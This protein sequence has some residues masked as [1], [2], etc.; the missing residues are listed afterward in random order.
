[1]HRNQCQTKVTCTVHNCAHHVSSGCGCDLEE[2]RV[3]QCPG[4][5]D[6]KTDDQSMCADYEERLL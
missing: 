3:C 4:S 5:R 2:I 6:G 1:M